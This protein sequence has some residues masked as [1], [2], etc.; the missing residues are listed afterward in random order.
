MVASFQ[1]VEASFQVV[2]ASFQ[3]VVASFQV[4][5]TSFQVVM[6]GDWPDLLTPPQG[7]PLAF[8]KDRR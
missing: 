8:E 2:V 3:V 1:V 6:V 7:V 5:K 4:V